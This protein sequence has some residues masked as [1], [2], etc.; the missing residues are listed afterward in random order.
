[1]AQK[2]TVKVRVAGVG[3]V[4]FALSVAR[5]WKLWLPRESGDV[6]V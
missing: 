4:F 2:A 1:M 3:S 6:G 5:T